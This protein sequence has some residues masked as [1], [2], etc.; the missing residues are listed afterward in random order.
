MRGTWIDVGAHHGENTLQHAAQNP[1][2]RV[3]AIEPNLRAAAKLMGQA[4]NFIVI[5]MAIAET[6]GSAGF[7]INSFEMASSLLPLNEE[8]VRTWVGVGA[9]NEE[10][11]VIVPTIRLDSRMEVMGIQKVDFLKIDAQGS[12]LAVVKST[13]S[14]LRDIAKIALEVSVAAQPLYKGAPSK[15]EVLTF[16]ENA[17]FRLVDAQKQTNGQEENLTFERV[18]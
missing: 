10:C 3:Y 1:G 6:N 14:R 2:L 7:H 13:G 12:D 17:G 4:A 18:A 15:E 16:L 5:P 11:N 9:H 8:A